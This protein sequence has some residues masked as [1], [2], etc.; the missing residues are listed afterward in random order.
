MNI[1]QLAE[2]IGNNSWFAPG[3]R[4]CAGCN[5]GI[6]AKFV[7]NFAQFKG[8]KVITVLA[9]GC[10]EVA[11]TI[12]PYT[13]WKTAYMHNAFEN[14]AATASGIGAALKS[15]KKK[16]LLKED[17][18]IVVF[19]G[20]G[21]TY[22]IGLQSLSGAL[23]RKHEFVYICYDN[24]AYM[25]TGIQ[26][27]SATPMLASTTTTPSGKV[28]KGKQQPRKDLIAIAAAHDVYAAQTSVSHLQ[29]FWKKLE[30]AFNDQPAVLNVLSPC[31][32]GWYFPPDQGIKIAKLAVETNYWPLYEV[33]H[34][35][36]ILNYEPKQR[37]PII[38]WLKTQGRFKHLLQ[39]TQENEKLIA[40]LQEMVDKRFEYIKKLARAT[41]E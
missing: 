21:G 20:D 32:R 2:K 6:I 41:S 9:T 26:R 16:G 25:N 27:S 5:A 4:L 39:P 38:E 10:L 35:R 24:E 7:L 11:T 28:S 22:D 19:G 30:K 34:G 17:Y 13:S 33:D 3:H 37:K 36:W 14:A 8:Y 31:T 40:Q 15:L 23:E 12:F 18:K 1:K 29:D